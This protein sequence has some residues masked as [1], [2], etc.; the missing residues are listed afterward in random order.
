MTPEQASEI[1][2]LL[3][4]IAESL[5]CIGSMILLY[6]FIRIFGALK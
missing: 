2:V 3:G 4:K 1:I 5:S 6:V